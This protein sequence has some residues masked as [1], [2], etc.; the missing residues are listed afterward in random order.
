MALMN[1]W[2]S[3]KRYLLL[4]SII[5]I[6]V[7]GWVLYPSD[8]DIFDWYLKAEKGN[9]LSLKKLQVIGFLGNEQANYCL[10]GLYK[11]GKGVKKDFEKSIEY[12]QKTRGRGSFE[13]AEIK[14]KEEDWIEAKRYYEIA[15]DSDYGWGCNAE[16][17][18]GIIYQ[19]GYGV[20]IDY[21]RA[22]D[23]YTKA[24][25]HG[26]AASALNLADIYALGIGVRQDYAKAIALY[27]KAIVMDLL[28][29][30]VIG[31][32][33]YRLGV[34]YID[35]K[36][37]KKDTSEGIKWLQKSAAFFNDEAL[38]RLGYMHMYG[39]PVKMDHVKAREF[40]GKAC[41]NGNRQGCILFKLL[42]SQ[43]E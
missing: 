1:L 4:V 10:G 9:E 13:I 38:M 7:G 3:N 23:W 14:R 5:L 35:G 25:A 40:F 32:A 31:K 15:A 29:F 22:I 26:S 39:N 16:N 11:G 20:P 18:L 28:Q 12:Y 36:G 17:I 24:V 34:I 43:V 42:S 2:R 21:N 37:V 30:E 27:R 33:A 41:D 19:N 8:S 6:G